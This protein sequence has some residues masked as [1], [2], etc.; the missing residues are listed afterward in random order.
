V[1]STLL[2]IPHHPQRSDGDCLAACAA[3]VLEHLSM[4]IDYDRL[5]RPSSKYPSAFPESSLNSPGWSSTIAM[6]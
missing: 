4:L 6:Q 2:T 5:L 1:P 3:M